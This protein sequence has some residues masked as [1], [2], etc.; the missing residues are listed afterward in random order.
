[1]EKEHKELQKFINPFEDT[2]PDSMNVKRCW[3]NI[4]VQGDL[5]D[6]VQFVKVSSPIYSGCKD[7]KRIEQTW[8]I[9]FSAFHNNPV[10]K[11]ACFYRRHLF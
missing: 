2:V 3:R 7:I 10:T 1:M 11:P 4:V 6:A 8:Q 9:I 5:W